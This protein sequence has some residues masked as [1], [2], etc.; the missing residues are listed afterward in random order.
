M[1]SGLNPRTGEQPWICCQI[2]AREHY[3]IPRAL[4]RQRIPVRLFTDIWATARNRWL[5]PKK[6]R[7]R[8]HPEIADSR[9]ESWNLQ[10]LLRFLGS[11]VTGKTGWTEIIER[12]RWFEQQVSEH[13]KRVLGQM[14]EPAVVF[15]YSYAAE[16]ILEVARSEGCTTVLGQMDPALT[17]VEL[18]KKIEIQHGQGQSEWPPSAYWDKWHRECELSDH[19]IVN[20]EWSRTALLKQGIDED[21]M[22]VISLAFEKSAEPNDPRSLPAAFS[23]ERPLRVLFLGQVI[24]RKG[25]V[26]LCDAAAALKAEPIEWRVVGGGSADLLAR[27]REYENVVVT[28]QI[29]RHDATREY[30]QADVFILPTHSD[31][32][33]LTQLEAASH[34][35][36]IIASKRCGDVVEHDRNGLVLNAISA[37][38][39]SEAVLRFVKSPKFLRQLRIDQETRDIFGI[40]ELGQSLRQLVRRSQNRGRA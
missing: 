25:I 26:E 10:S 7:Q 20:S 33:A 35:L 22:E 28:G 15:S 32:F 9:V 18:V 3:A 39:I 34:G 5:L 16:K 37:K 36:P 40:S 23:H 29:S 31:G 4:I 17:E 19:I 30:Q 13:L 1:N 21:K 24:P 14:A 8:Q 12:N 27:L 2:G 11:Q 38:E 6:W